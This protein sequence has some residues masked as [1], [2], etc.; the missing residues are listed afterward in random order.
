MIYEVHML[1][2]ID[3]NTVRGLKTNLQGITEAE[4]DWQPHP[5]ANSVRWIMGHLIWSEEWFR[6]T[7]LDTGRY[8]TDDHALSYDVDSIEEIH[9]RFDRA[10]RSY[11]AAL[12]GLSAPDL[13]RNVSY[14]GEP[15][16]IRRV[17]VAHTTH[18][19]GSRYQIRY[20]RGTYSR[21]HGTDKKVFDRY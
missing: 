20:I 3:E 12:E 4:L 18:L 16:D 19:V 2:E 21:A 13:S 8:L 7:L 14:M 5:E 15:S 1:D 11:R 10:R 9:E 17:V 6:D